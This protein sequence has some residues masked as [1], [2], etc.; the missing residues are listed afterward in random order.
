MV[1]WVGKNFDLCLLICF[2]SLLIVGCLRGLL[3]LVEFIFFLF[4]L[5]LG[6]LRWVVLM[7]LVCDSIICDRYIYYELRFLYS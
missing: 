3:V 2:I 5:I 6:L 1:L 7:L 4:G